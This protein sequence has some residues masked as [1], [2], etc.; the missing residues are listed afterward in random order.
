MQPTG[1]GTADRSL[2][3]SKIENTTKGASSIS[4][5]Q[6]RNIQISVPLTTY[7]WNKVSIYVMV[8]DL[9]TFYSN[10]IIF[11]IMKNCSFVLTTVATK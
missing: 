4:D 2:T 11:R 6:S 9:F 5:T 7:F 10:K 8:F 3:P 1:L